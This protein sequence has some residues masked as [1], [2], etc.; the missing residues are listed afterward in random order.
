MICRGAKMENIDQTSAWVAFEQGA[1]DIHPARLPEAVEVVAILRE[2]AVWLENRRMPLWQPA[3][4]TPERLA[5]D[6]ARGQYMLVRW[7]GSPAGV[8]KYQRADAE[9]WPDAIP[10]EAAY[11]HRV[12][13]CRRYAGSGLA[14]LLLQA[15]AA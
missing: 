7:H 13:V 3:A 9:I 2:A 4:F 11:I 15:A 1:I 10:G 14:A 12:A 5:A 6:V 8:F